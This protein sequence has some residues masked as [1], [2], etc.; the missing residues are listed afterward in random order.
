MD[1]KREIIIKLF[2][3]NFKPCQIFRKLKNLG[4]NLKLITR[5]IK[6]FKETGSFKIRPKFINKRTVR[7]KKMIKIV[8]ERIR[9]NPA[10]SGN[11]LARSLN[12]SRRSMGRILHNDLGLKAYKKQKISG[13][14]TALKVARMEKCKHLLDWHGGDEIIF[15]DEKI[16]LLQDSHNQQ[17]DRVYGVTLQDIPR[18]KLEVERFQNASRVMVWGAISPRGTLP[19]LFIDSNVKINAACYLKEILQG[20][21]LQNAINLYG[22]DYFCFQQDSAPAHKAKICQEWCAQ[23]LPDFIPA[24]EWPAASPDLNPLDFSIWGYM[25][26]KIGKRQHKKYEFE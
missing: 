18:N 7:S 17:N 20:H 16:F 5:T 24:S 9:R 15:S 3:Q 21:L 6:R 8:R 12:I 14:T 11:K 22:D 1:A 13:L 26:S 23:N 4:V 2:N 25:L 19:L 10:Q